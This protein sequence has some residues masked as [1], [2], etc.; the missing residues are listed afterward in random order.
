MTI[1][2]TDKQHK[3]ALSR[4]LEKG[5][6]AIGLGAAFLVAPSFLE[7]S[8]TTIAIAAGLPMGGWIAMGIGLVLLDFRFSVQNKARKLANLP[9]RD[10]SKL[11][12]LQQRHGPAV[13]SPENAATN[14]TFT[15]A[16]GTAPGS[17][18]TTK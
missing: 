17:E 5:V 9:R 8:P 15:R 18:V 6:R 14:Q 13:F 2:T 3:R 12:S 1:P 7:P 11:E 10:N 4:L 16:S